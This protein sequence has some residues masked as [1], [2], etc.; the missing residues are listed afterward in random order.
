MSR[1]VV[2]KSRG[3]PTGGT[4]R[5]PPEVL[6]PSGSPAGGGGSAASPSGLFTEWVDLSAKLAGSS[7]LFTPRCAH[8]MA[9]MPRRP[10][11]QASELPEV[12][13]AG[14][15]SEM[16]YFPLSEVLFSVFEH[17]FPF[18]YKMNLVSED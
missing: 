2:P 5:R 16:D 18:N 4:A 13:F 1:P 12:I 3:A 10:A 11:A 9:I 6:F 14:G 17:L 8:A 15:C 7:T